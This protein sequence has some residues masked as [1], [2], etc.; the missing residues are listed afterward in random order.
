L[1]LTIERSKAIKCPSI[2]YHLAGVKKLQQIVVN[3]QILD[4]FLDPVASEQVHSTFAGLWGFDMNEEGSAA[5]EMALREPSRFVMKPQREGGGNNFYQEDIIKQLTPIKDSRDREAYIL[6]ELIR[7][8][9]ISNLIIA[10][11]TQLPPEE[12]VYNQIVGELGIFGAILGSA[13]GVTF[14]MEAGH[15]L[16]SKNLGVNEGGISAGFGAVDSPFLY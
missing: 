16:R 10:P 9:V 4:K 1:R 13:E 3:R 8:P 7:P 14:N 2:N 12:G 15:V 5:V 6:M 11:G